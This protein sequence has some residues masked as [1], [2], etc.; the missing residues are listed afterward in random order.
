[1]VGCLRGVLKV[2]GQNH[3]PFADEEEA[4][5][6]CF[7]ARESGGGYPEW[8]AVFQDSQVKGFVKFD[9]EGVVF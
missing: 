2:I 6:A 4:M 3:K 9:E 1:M 8:E 5:Q 7:R